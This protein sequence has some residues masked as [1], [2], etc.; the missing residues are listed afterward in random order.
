L[1]LGSFQAAPLHSQLACRS[2]GERVWQ[3]KAD[4]SKVF[5]GRG[6]RLGKLTCHPERRRSGWINTAPR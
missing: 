2:F 4:F 6:F 1:K 5:N 3:K